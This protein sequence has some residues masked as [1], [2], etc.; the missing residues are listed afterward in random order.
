MPSIAPP[1]HT[2]RQTSTDDWIT[3]KWLLDRLGP[4]DLDPCASLVQPW[5]CASRQ[6]TVCENGLIQP[7]EGLVFMN[8]PYGQHTAKWLARLAS[9]GNGVALVFARTETR[10]FFAHVW[11]KARRL[12]FLRGRLTFHRPD[13]SGSPAKHN[14]GGP[15][16]LIAYGD[17]AAQRL[18]DAYDLG[19]LVEI[20]VPEKGRLF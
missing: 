9:H 1:N 3:P 11:P 6:W 18:M 8:P 15:S 4:F 10:M 7:W 14:S 5:R 12:L 16:V 17:E 20:M 2:R 19:T 13:G